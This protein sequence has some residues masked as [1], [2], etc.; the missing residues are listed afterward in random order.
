MTT[1]GAF[2]NTTKV[3]PTEG[4]RAG[5]LTAF[6]RLEDVRSA[7]TVHKPPLVVAE[8]KITRAMALVLGAKAEVDTLDEAGRAA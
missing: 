3:L 5:L 4:L 6:D 2:V 8:E 7:C 1:E